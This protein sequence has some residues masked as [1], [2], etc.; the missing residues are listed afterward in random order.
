MIEFCRQ[1]N[2]PVVDI[3]I[4]LDQPGKRNYPHD[5][6]P[7]KEVHME[8]CNMLLDYFYQTELIK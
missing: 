2:I 7:V 4:D 5:D 8:Y 3:S 6:H 1:N